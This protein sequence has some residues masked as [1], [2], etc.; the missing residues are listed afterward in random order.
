MQ[1]LAE[2]DLT[3]GPT[4]IL[5]STV[6]ARKTIFIHSLGAFGCSLPPPDLSPDIVRTLLP[7]EPQRWMN[8]TLKEP[9]LLIVSLDEKNLGHRMISLARAILI[10]TIMNRRLVIVWSREE[11][12]GLELGH[13]LVGDFFVVGEIG[14]LPNVQSP[15]ILVENDDLLDRASNA[16]EHLYVKHNINNL[17]SNIV[18]DVELNKV[19]AGL[20]FQYAVIEW[21]LKHAVGRQFMSLLVDESWA[22]S[23]C[24]ETDVLASLKVG[25]TSI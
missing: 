1:S 23:G 17:G 3:R 18:D 5:P 2:Y 15:L 10:S 24:K 14:D 8:V 12:G 7:V 25:G 22:N 21:S 20:K 19:I 11:V 4:W 16:T 9:F 6:F 13:V